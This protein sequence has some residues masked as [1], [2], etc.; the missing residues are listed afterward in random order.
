V[1][2]WRRQSRLPKTIAYNFDD[3]ALQGSTQVSVPGTPLDPV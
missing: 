3:G 2:G 1:S